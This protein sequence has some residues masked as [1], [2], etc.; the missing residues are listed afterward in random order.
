MTAP[1]AV[2]LGIE[3]VGNARDYKVGTQKPISGEGHLEPMV[4]LHGQCK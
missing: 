2:G 3:L 4:Q 1:E